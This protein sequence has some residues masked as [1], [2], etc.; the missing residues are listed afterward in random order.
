MRKRSKYRPKKVLVNPVGY[1]LEGMTPVGKHDSFL[2]DLKIKN[3]LSMS[4]LTQGKAT[5]EDMDKLINMAN[6][7]EALYRL[8]F[9]ADYKDV[10]Q[11]GS[12]ALLAIA[13]RG[14]ETN[15]FVL[16]GAEMKA[17]NTLMEL[18]DAQMEVIT[19]KDME[20][21]V[22]LVENERKQKRMTSI[23]ERK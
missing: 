10:L 16:W 20:R 14:A 8:G 7:A 4:S 13:R 5:R 6:I 1:V 23:I 18:H 17:L 11:E 15:R 19:V 3:H 2:L 22:A 9:G 12:S 21:A